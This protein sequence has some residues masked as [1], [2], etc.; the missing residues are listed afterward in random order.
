MGNEV[1]LSLCPCAFTMWEF[2]SLFLF[3]SGCLFKALRPTSHLLIITGPLTVSTGENILVLVQRYLI[4]QN[5]MVRLNNQMYPFSSLFFPKRSTEKREDVLIIAN[6]NRAAQLDL[7]RFGRQF[8]LSPK[9][10]GNH[11]L[12]TALQGCQ[13]IKGG[14]KVGARPDFTNQWRTWLQKPAFTLSCT[15]SSS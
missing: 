4:I 8:L 15:H 10:Y 13:C 9:K 3:F 5:C 1:F 7:L 11:F 12:V 14:L 2:H 6:F